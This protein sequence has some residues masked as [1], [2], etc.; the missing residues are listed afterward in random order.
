MTGE[1]KTCGMKCPLTGCPIAMVLAATIVAFVVT[2]GFDW[3]FHGI[4]M[5][6]A[7]EAT[8]DMWRPEEEM[9]NFF[10][11]C[12]IYHGVLAFGIAGLYCWISRF[13]PCSGKTPKAGLKFGFFVGLIIGI[14]HFGSYIWMPIPMDMAINWLI[15]S[16]VWGMLL[17][18]VLSQLGRLCCKKS[19]DKGAA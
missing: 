18:F 9:Q 5:K 7:Y 17:G 4:Y 12:L 19:C 15:G 10:H 16:I 14:S 2:M 6:E 8:K 13:L 11:I 1:G 3:V